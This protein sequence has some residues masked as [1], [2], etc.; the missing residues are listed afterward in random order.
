MRSKVLV[1]RYLLL[2]RE[3]QY[4]L[5]MDIPNKK[6]LNV[7]LQ[8]VESL[9]KDA[10][11]NE[12]EPESIFG[13]DKDVFYNDLVSAFPTRIGFYDSKVKEH[14][15]RKNLILVS[16]SFMLFV[17]FT[18]NW[19]NGNIPVFIFGLKWYELSNDYSR[20]YGYKGQ[21]NK[22]TL[23]L[24]NLDVNKGLILFN[25]GQSKISI[26]E[27]YISN[28]GEYIVRVNQR[29]SGTGKAGRLVSV[30]MENGYDDWYPYEISVFQLSA[31]DETYDANIRVFEGYIEPNRDGSTFEIVIFSRVRYPN[32]EQISNEFLAR[33][34]KMDLRILNLTE[35][36]WSRR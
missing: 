24:I 30:T 4:H 17:L 22:V 36:L 33:G 19:A 16:L 3:L 35:F 23:D 32:A 21:S 12:Q 11:D 15:T 5:R 31:Y 14:K 6:E 20:G 34:G 7:A 13:E 1:G 25:D 2:F 9:L 28:L 10:Q 29:G 8:G 27:V 18:Y 26:E